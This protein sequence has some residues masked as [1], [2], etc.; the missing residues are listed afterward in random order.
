M[1]VYDQMAKEPTIPTLTGLECGPAMSLL[2]EG[3]KKFVLACRL[4]GRNWSRAARIAGYEGTDQYMSVQGYRMAH[5]PKVQAAM[6][7]MASKNMVAAVP[8]LTEE[9]VRRVLDPKTE[10]KDFARLFPLLTD[11][12]GMHAKTEH[13]INVT[14]EL[15][16]KAALIAALQARLAQNPDI[17]GFIPGPLLAELE[18]KGETVDAEYVEVT[19]ARDPD[20]LD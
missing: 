3:Q 10:N 8:E 15:G 14:H 1:I 17:R 6:M 11:R 4:V 12:I 7:E 13:N 20:G 16:N 9:L 5:N 19:P 2:N 18:Q